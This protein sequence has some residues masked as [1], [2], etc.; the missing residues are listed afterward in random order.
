[1][2]YTRVLKFIYS[3]YKAKIKS[4]AVRSDDKESLTF[5]LLEYLK[6]NSLE[7]MVDL[8]ADVKLEYLITHNREGIFHI[9]FDSRLRFIIHL[10]FMT[11]T[12]HSKL[13]LLREHCE[14]FFRSVLQVLKDK[15]SL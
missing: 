14:F 8:E 3:R 9:E 11:D 2:K 6:Q 7:N 1:M 13:F 12:V 10:I 15:E 4:P 5:V